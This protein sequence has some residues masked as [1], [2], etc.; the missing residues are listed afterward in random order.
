MPGMNYRQKHSRQQRRS[1]LATWLL[2]GVCFIATLVYLRSRL[3]IID[4]SYEYSSLQKELKAL[5]ND[6]A[7][8]RLEVGR[9]RSPARIE[10]IARQKLGLKT[11]E[12][13]TRNITVV[14]S[15]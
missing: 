10:K 1:T 8:L 9:L 6:N 12:E 15:Q 3:W 5:K 4:L 13:I 7:E 11:R 2:V 14:L